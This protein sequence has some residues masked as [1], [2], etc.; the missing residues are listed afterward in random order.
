MINQ[1]CA[2]RGTVLCGS[3]RRK[4]CIFLAIFFSFTSLAAWSQN[5]IVAGTVRN[6]QN[7]PLAGITVSQKGTGNS[8][9]SNEAGQYR[10]QVT[11]NNPVLIFS[12]VGVKRTEMPVDNRSE[13]NI[14]LEI[15]SSQLEDVVVVAYGSQKKA[16]LSGAV[17]SVKGEEILKSPAINVSNSLAG[18][19]PGLT[20][21]A[22]GGE[23]GND[24]SN[25]LVRGINTF[26]NSSPLF[27][28]DG[29]PLP[30]SDK[31]Q[32]IDPSVIESITVMKDASA[33]IYGAEAANGVILITT[34]RGKAGKIQATASYNQGFSQPTRLPDLLSSDEI[35]VIHNEII[36][37]G[38]AS[39]L[40]P[41]K[42]TDEEIRKFKDGSD[43]WRYPNTDWVND[44]LQKWATQNYAN[45][46]LSG[47]TE[48]LRGLV[49][50][51]RRTQ[52][53]VFKNSAGNYQQYD[54]RANVDMNPSQYI[55]FSIDLNGR[56]DDRKFPSQNATR[57]YYQLLSASPTRHAYWPNGELGE[58]TSPNTGSSPVATSTGLG[59]YSN[60]KNYVF[61][62]TAKLNIKIPWV[63]GLS[64][65]GA[66]TLDRNFAFSKSW[67]IP[68]SYNE[69]DGI[70]VDAND[71]PVLQP[72]IVGTERIL[73]Q[74]NNNY[75]NY[76]VNVIGNYE[77]SF[78][79]HEIK[80]M[81]GA[82]RM[83]RKSDFFNVT[84]RGFDA[85]NLDQLVFGSTNGQ[86]INGAAAGADRWQNYFGRVNYDYDSK[87]LLE[88]V[89]RYQASSKFSRNTRWGFFPG[90]SVGYR[91]SEENFWKDNLSAIN[92]FKIRASL[93][94]TGNDFVQSFQYL[95]LYEIVGSSDYPF[96]YVSQVGANGALS[97]ETG[98]QEGVAPYESTWENA[99]QQ[100]VGF[101]AEFMGGKLSVTADYFNNKRTD[102]LT[103][104]LGGIP[105]STGI[106]P[107][108]QNIGEFRNRGFDFNAL[109]SD[110]A[111]KLTYRIGINGLYAKNKLLFFD[112]TAGIPD[113][114]KR[115][116]HPIGAGTFFQV[117]GVY[118]NGDD[119]VK[120]PAYLGANQP[121]DLIFKDMNEDGAIDSKDLVR[122]YKTDVPTFSGGLT[123]D[124]EYRNFDLG[125]LIQ[126]ATGGQ[127]YLRP[128][129]D[130][131]GNY[132]QV[133]YDKRWTPENPNTGY[134]RIWSGS[135][136]NWAD[137]NAIFNT[138]FLRKTDF[139]R[140]K[141]IELGYTLPASILSKAKIERLRIYVNALNLLTHAP[142]MK[143]FGTDPELAI[144]EN[145]QFYGESYP[146][147]RVVN[148]G[149]S[150]NF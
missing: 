129:F 115:T 48:K 104:P 77:K 58:I 95:A 144:A 35:A 18:R 14:Q 71:I 15:S 85:N 39:V 72:T 65:T 97:H 136:P 32:R 86:V 30:Q 17:A 12:G 16:T 93:G 126:G 91:I 29:I 132:L 117:I 88:F 137:P 40:H 6:T 5:K 24:F 80:F 118:Q 121:G 111:G 66:A 133:F 36:D 141:N 54:V 34:K 19:V 110:R 89:W 50:L 20:V 96:H 127:R 99:I 2:G 59:G 146:I 44:V 116:G 84:R 102:I 90:V 101:D 135:S 81:A 49:S 67:S 38:G 119:A 114:Q 134:P 53:G 57:T 4:M 51:S 31:L 103:P 61:N 13:L 27:V 74:G 120:F 140:L 147:Q 28:V 11:G 138:L 8:T 76:L 130:I 45:V 70:S 33:A 69:W 25:I 150:L 142:D 128:T 46:Q 112:E 83:E 42:Y 9:S 23:P 55:L 139:V 21:V 52:D 60:M 125:I 73:S 149:F 124:F 122:S 100:N 109:Y 98:L 22:Q 75:N 47:G 145:A 10:L 123:L 82:E 68:I 107:S 106:R 87:Y 131:D 148:V 64:F 37:R 56:F 1:N 79:D 105:T 63:K 41:A 7:E 26:R 113:Y 78:G 108:D 92:S 62:T 143:D 3:I 94:K 43:P